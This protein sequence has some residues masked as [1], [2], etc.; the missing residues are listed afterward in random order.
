LKKTC[1]NIENDL[2]NLLQNR[3]KNKSGIIYCQSR[4]DCEQL[5]EK[6]STQHLIKCS[7]YHAELD[8]ETRSEI[9][10]NWM[11]DEI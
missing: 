10:A 4:K 5:S 7:F 2:V 9:Q 3:F 11:K 1:K 6:L 8:A